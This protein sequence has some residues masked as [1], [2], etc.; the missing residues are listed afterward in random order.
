MKGRVNLSR[1]ALEH[2]PFIRY[3]IVVLLL[4]GDRLT[5]AMAATLFSQGALAQSA[6][7]AKPI[8]VT[9]RGWAIAMN[10]PDF[11]DS[12]DRVPCS[13]RREFRNR[14]KPGHRHA[15]KDERPRRGPMSLR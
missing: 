5:A 14:P 15:W 3:L 12:K 2:I 1:W 11:S 8:R 13:L 10:E 6:Y 4:G 9:T 7:P